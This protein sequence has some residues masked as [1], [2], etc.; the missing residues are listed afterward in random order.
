[1]W[2]FSTFALLVRKNFLKVYGNGNILFTLWGPISISINLYSTS[3]I[4]TL[5][6]AKAIDFFSF[7]FQPFFECFLDSSIICTVQVISTNYSLINL[8][9]ILNG[10]FITV[11]FFIPTFNYT[12]TILFTTSWYY[13]ITV[14]IIYSYFNCCKFN[15]FS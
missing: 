12:F 7:F 1:M 4:H 10:G 14:L 2:E 13:H 8:D 15:S 6:H 9:Y 5:Y 3:P 11:K